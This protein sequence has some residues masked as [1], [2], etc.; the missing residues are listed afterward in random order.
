MFAVALLSLGSTTGSKSFDSGAKRVF[1]ISRDNGGHNRSGRKAQ[2]VPSGVFG[3]RLHT[4]DL[5]PQKKKTIGNLWSAMCLPGN[6]VDI[7]IQPR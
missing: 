2:K 4:S 5:F 1:S 3:R 6:L 7:E